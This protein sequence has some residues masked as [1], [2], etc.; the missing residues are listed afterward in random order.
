MLSW[1]NAIPREGHLD[2]VY[3]IIAYLKRNDYISAYLEKNENTTMVF[4]S[5]LLP[6]IDEKKFKQVKWLDFYGD[7][8][9]AISSNMPNQE[10]NRVK[11]DSDTRRSRTGIRIYTSTSLQ[12]SGIARGKQQYME[13]N[14]WPTRLPQ[15]STRNTD[16]NSMFSIPI[17]R[18][19][20]DFYNNRRVVTTSSSMLK[21]TLSN[22]H[23][24][25]SYH[26]VRDIHT[27]HNSRH[28][29][30]HRNLS[31]GSI[32][33][34]L[35]DITEKILTVEDHLLRDGDTVRRY[36]GWRRFPVAR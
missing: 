36:V 25:M 18:W 35:A 3:Y 32:Y 27:R 26:R 7:V 24:G 5:A 34:A 17:D 8:E 31:C 2:D 22:K 11:M 15:N 12:L 21:S 19:K 6:F 14:W 9:E 13:A 4:D 28:K 1:H 30:R 23:N 16:I 10:G 20:D 29:G 33:E